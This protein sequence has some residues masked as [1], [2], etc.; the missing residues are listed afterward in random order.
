M[1]SIKDNRGFTLVELIVVLVILG[2]TRGR[3]DPVSDR[4]HRQGEAADGHRGGAG[5]L[6][7]LAGGAVRVLR[8]VSGELCRVVQVPIDDRRR[9]D[10]QAGAHLQRCAGRF[11][12]EPERPTE[13]GSSSRRIAGQV[14]AIWTVRIK[15][16]SA[17]YL[18]Q[19]RDPD[20]EHAAEQ[21]FYH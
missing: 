6:D 10:D 7:G 18:R 12:E 1:R 13:A 15:C 3:S 2:D 8:H 16:R 17:L 9:K 11:A 21:L 5:R 20:R 19:R 4:L 14:L